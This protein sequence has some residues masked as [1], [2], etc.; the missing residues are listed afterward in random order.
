MVSSSSKVK[1][2]K[3]SAVDSQEKKRVKS[4]KVRDRD[5]AT[6]TDASDIFEPTEQNCR[7]VFAFFGGK[8]LV[9]VHLA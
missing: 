6:I 9:I 4:S 1:R 5:E 2:K 3:M 7:A 8:P